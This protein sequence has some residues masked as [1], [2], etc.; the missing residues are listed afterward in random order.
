[1]VGGSLQVLLHPPPLKLV[2]F[3]EKKILL[4]DEEQQVMHYHLQ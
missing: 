1:M 3:L 2:A 4:Q